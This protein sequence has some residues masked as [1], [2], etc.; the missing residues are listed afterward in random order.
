MKLINWHSNESE[1]LVVGML[2]GEQRANEN[3]SDR[4]NQLVWKRKP[5][6]CIR[7][8]HFFL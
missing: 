8:R 1:I 6:Q 3:G 5:S 2:R 7:G 4:H